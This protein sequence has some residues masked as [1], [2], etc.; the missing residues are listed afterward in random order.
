MLLAVNSTLIYTETE[1]LP[2]W[3]KDFKQLEYLYGIASSTSSSALMVFTSLTTPR[4]CRHIEGKH[5][6]SSLLS[7]PE[8]LFSDM[9]LLTCVHLGVHPRLAILPSFRGLSNLKR[10]TLAYLLSIAEMPSF[11]ALERLERLQLVYLPRLRSVPDMAPLRSLRAFTVFRPNQ[12]CCNGFIGACNLSHPYCTAN[13]DLQIPE[14]A[15]IQEETLRS[16]VATQH[17]FQENA[18]SVCQ[19]AYSTYTETVSKENIE[20]CDGTPFRQCQDSTASGTGICFN[21]RFQV[22]TCTLDPLKIQIRQQQILRN[23]GPDCDPAVEEWLGCAEN[24]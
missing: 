17:F 5:G 12:L 10:L 20:V 22:L 16:A 4:C 3:S 14:A 24:D 6:S 1:T 9:S 8:D 7:L 11:E 13:A 23:I 2:S 19:I 21:T 18:D 15:C